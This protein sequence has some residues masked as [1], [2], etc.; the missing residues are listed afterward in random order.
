MTDYDIKMFFIENKTAFLWFP[1]FL[2]EEFTPSHLEPKTQSLPKKGFAG[3][4]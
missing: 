1:E 4:V 2:Y 3:K